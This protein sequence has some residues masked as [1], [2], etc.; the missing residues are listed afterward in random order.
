MRGL[1]FAVDEDL[2]DL[3]VGPQLLI[4][5][6]SVSISRMTQDLY[7][8]SYSRVPYEIWDRES[9]C[10]L[11]LLLNHS[12]GGSFEHQRLFTIQIPR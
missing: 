5:K 9:A 6:G 11:D 10:H 7:M 12:T 4:L 1:T 8:R 3:V 2:L